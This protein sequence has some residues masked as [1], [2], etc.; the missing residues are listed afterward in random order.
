M[1]LRN[2]AIDGPPGAGKSTVGFRVAQA[3][4]MAFLDTGAMYRALALRALQLGADPEDEPELLKLLSSTEIR[5]L[6]ADRA[7]GRR[8]TLIMDGEDVTWALRSPDVDRIVAIV[9]KHGEVRKAMVP[10]QR[11]LALQAPSVVV[12][13]DIGTAVLPDADLKIFLDA[14]PQ[15]RARRR[16]AELQALGEDISLQEVLEDIL[17]R[18]H[19]ETTRAVSPLIVPPGA[20]VVDTDHLDVDAVVEVV[21]ELIRLKEC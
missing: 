11:Q 8:Y 15:E 16:W 1:K 7:D 10:L 20:V 14:S 2:L 9:A 12:G 13:R 18:E 3:L 19:L 21:L 4:G 6:P 5:I 17:R